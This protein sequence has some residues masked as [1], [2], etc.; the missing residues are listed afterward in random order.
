MAYTRSMYF[1]G[2]SPKSSKLQSPRRPVLAA[3]NITKQ[4]QEG[5][6]VPVLDRPIDN[7][8]RNQNEVSRTKSDEALNLTTSLLNVVS[9]NNDL[10]S[11]DQV[12]SY[13]RDL[14]D[15]GLGSR[16]NTNRSKH[17]WCVQKQTVT[18]R[19][20]SDSEQIRADSKNL[21]VASTRIHPN[22]N[23]KRS[24]QNAANATSTPVQRFHHT[25]TTT[26]KNNIMHTAPPERSTYLLYQEQLTM[27]A[28][29]NTHNATTGTGTTAG[30]DKWMVA[31]ELRR[32][33]SPSIA[34]RKGRPDPQ[35]EADRVE[36][37][38][39]VREYNW[40]T[41]RLYDRI[42]SHRQNHQVHPI[43]DAQ[44][45]CHGNSNVSTDDDQVFSSIASQQGYEQFENTLSCE[46]TCSS[47]TVD[48][49][50]EI[51]VMDL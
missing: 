16:A 7:S 36:L 22:Q 24:S 17:V 29:C 18:H 3:R 27:P 44:Q 30:L 47:T 20:S 43:V 11:Q 23:T 51:F 19:Q 4:Q 5:L 8:R 32:R 15:H 42:V 9:A 14:V 33:R 39:A 34:I 10:R 2:C 31:D 46:A 13:S 6:P 41:W 1:L 25:I 35:A 38:N 45:D 21:L 50:D 37:A 12:Q 40:A 26:N 49:D 28:Q 48:D